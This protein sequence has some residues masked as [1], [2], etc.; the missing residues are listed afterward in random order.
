MAMTFTTL[1]KLGNFQSTASTH[2]TPGPGTDETHNN[3]QNDKKLSN[4][5]TTSL[6]CSVPKSPTPSAMTSP[7]SLLYEFVYRAHLT[8]QALDTAG[9]R[10]RRLAEFDSSEI[11]R[12]LSLDLLDD[13]PIDN[14][15]AMANIYIAIA[16]FENSVH[17]LI[18]KVLSEE[19]GANRWD[20]CVSEKIRRTKSVGMSNE[21]TIRLTTP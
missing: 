7:E 5:H 20:A 4:D 8:E 17:D 9:R 13:H 6:R 19:I 15:R 10:N 3:N 21:R 1:V 14:A 16:G 12:V 2:S 11:A 18:T